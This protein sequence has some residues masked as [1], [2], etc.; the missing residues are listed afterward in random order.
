VYGLVRYNAE[1]WGGHSDEPSGVFSGI[2]QGG[3][4]GW[5]GLCY[6]SGRG[7]GE[8]TELWE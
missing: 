2:L 3:R 4:G 7:A 5:D 8:E 6:P 1:D